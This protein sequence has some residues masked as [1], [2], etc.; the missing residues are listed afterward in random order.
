LVYQVPGARAF[1]MENTT[2]VGNDGLPKI[3]NF[4]LPAHYYRANPL[5]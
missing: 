1:E 3:I 2:D 4:K 5:D